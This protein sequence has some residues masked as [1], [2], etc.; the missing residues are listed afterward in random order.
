MSQYDVLFVHITLAPVTDED[1]ATIIGDPLFEVPLPNPEDYED[2]PALKDASLCYEVHGNSGEIFNLISDGCTS[3]NALYKEGVLP[4]TTDLNFMSKIGIAADGVTGQCHTLEFDV[5]GCKAFFDG[6]EVPLN[7][8]SSDDRIRVRRRGSEYTYII[9][10]PNCGTARRLMMWV[11]CVNTTRLGEPR[12]DGLHF[13]VLYADGLQ[14]T[15]HGLLG[16]C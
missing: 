10:V 16:E 4:N 7:G 15:S 5:D 2:D 11:S 3:V 9:S 13:R 6:L 12:D 1:N 8:I 14:P